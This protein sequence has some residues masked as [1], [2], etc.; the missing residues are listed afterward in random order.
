MNREQ[1]ER[2]AGNIKA[3]ADTIEGIRCCHGDINREDGNSLLTCVLALESV[4]NGI[5]GMTADQ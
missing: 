5:E 3:I 1:L 2:I 4:A